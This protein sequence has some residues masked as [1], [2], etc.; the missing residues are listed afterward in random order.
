MP[1]ALGEDGLDLLLEQGAELR[2]QDLGVQ[3]VRVLD[4][5]QDL[6]GAELLEGVH[7]E[8]FQAQGE[9]CR[10]GLPAEVAEQ[11]LVRQPA[12]EAGE[13]VQQRL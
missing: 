11:H 12:G 6:A 10:Q 9:G 3:L 5:A 7:V 4:V 13:A 2:L 8:P 1:Q